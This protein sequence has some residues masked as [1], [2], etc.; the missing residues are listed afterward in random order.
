MRAGWLHQTGRFNLDY[1][2]IN[3][4][5]TPFVTAGIGYQYLEADLENLPPEPCELGVAGPPAATS[6]D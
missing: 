4:R 2:I 6:Y 3:R 5:I 1:N